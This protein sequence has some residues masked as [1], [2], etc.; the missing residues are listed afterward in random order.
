MK[1]AAKQFGRKRGGRLNIVANAKKLGVCPS[2]LWRV[3]VGQRQSKSLLARYRALKAGQPI[4]EPGT[5][6]N[7]AHQASRTHR[8]AR[9][10]RGQTLTIAV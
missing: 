8:S 4:H 3:L 9:V 7:L 2:H 10:Q 1:C 6:K 5:G